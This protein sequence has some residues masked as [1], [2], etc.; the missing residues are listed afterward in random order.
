MENIVPKLAGTLIKFLRN[1]FQLP[2]EKY[3]DL[4][5]S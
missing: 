3:F 1:S 2:K 5:K 4:I